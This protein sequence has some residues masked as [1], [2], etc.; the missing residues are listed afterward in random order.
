MAKLTT[1]GKY[2]L[3]KRIAI[4]GMSE[5]FLASQGGLRGFERAVVVK[6]IREDLEAEPEVEQMFL[7]EARIAACLKHPNIVHLYDVGRDKGTAY[8]A[9]EYVFGRDLMDICTRARALGKQIPVP[10]LVKMMCDV[11]A[12]LHYA[13]FV[14]EYQD[15]PLHVIHRDVSPQNIMVS[16]DGVTKLGDFG[17]AKA[18]ARLSQTRAGVLKGKYAYMSP[19]QVRG[20]PLDHR[21]DQFSLAVVFYEALT[22]TRL[23]QRD[24]EF[25]TM[26]AVDRCHV[27]PLKVLR[28]D[29]PRRLVRVLRKAMRKNPRR[30]FSSAK[31]MERALHKLL[32]GSPVEQTERVAA[33]M[34]ELFT[35]ELKQRERAIARATGNDRDILMSTGFELIGIDGGQDLVPDPPLAEELY[36]RIVSEKQQE[37]TAIQ[38]EPLDG[39]GVVSDT[40]STQPAGKSARK[41]RSE[42][43][44]AVAVFLAVLLAGLL[45]LNHLEGQKPAPG[46]PGV[47]MAM[48]PAARAGLDGLL[49]VSVAPHVEV[50]IDGKLH[51]T[52]A[53]RDHPLPAGH[54]T[55]KMV[56]KRRSRSRSFE[57]DIVADR[58]YLLAP[59]DFQ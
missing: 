16:F 51:T 13:H 53:F 30:R 41:K 15:K 22:G 8:L 32:V 54:H 28:K 25:S 7:D 36:E 11:L 47:P 39:K 44:L 34:R 42:W 29:V 48:K 59:M 56:D 1:L 17:I 2:Q 5:I 52:G 14:A 20:K 55:V 3:I 31:E 50:Y 37:P 49:S 6:C 18:S 10:V 9:M 38:A 35:E 33:F 4:G 26:E 46:G 58:P 24:T 23:F 19:E 57:V 27:P 45:L 12:A 40:V 43:A 21:T